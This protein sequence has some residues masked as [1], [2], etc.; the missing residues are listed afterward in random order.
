[1]LGDDRPAVL[2]P[3]RLHIAEA[4]VPFVSTPSPTHHDTSAVHSYT[5]GTSLDPI[6]SADNP[7][8]PAL[9]PLS[10][11]RHEADHTTTILTLSHRLAGSPRPSHRGHLAVAMRT[12]RSNRRPPPF[13]AVRQE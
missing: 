9:A 7:A 3:C 1:M 5:T 11:D 4:L 13:P 8:N 2:V 10:F 6:R 12:L